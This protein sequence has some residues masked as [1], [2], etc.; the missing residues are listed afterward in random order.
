MTFLYFFLPFFLSKNGRLSRKHLV[1]RPFLQQPNS[2]RISTGKTV[3]QTQ[4]NIGVN[5]KELYCQKNAVILLV[6]SVFVCKCSFLTF[7]DSQRLEKSGEKDF[8][9]FRSIGTFDSC[10]CQKQELVLLALFDD[11]EN[12]HFCTLDQLSISFYGQD[13]LSRTTFTCLCVKPF[14]SESFS[15]CA[16]FMHISWLAY[17]LSAYFFKK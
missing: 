4:H 13:K 17:I 12:D 11:G 8:D 5:Q 16:L 9:T 1:S 6:T 15:S 10:Y 7:F 2:F 3:E 14:F